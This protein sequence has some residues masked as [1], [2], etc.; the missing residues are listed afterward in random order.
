[1]H[2]SNLKLSTRNFSSIQFTKFSLPIKRIQFTKLKQL[3][4]VVKSTEPGFTQEIKSG[5]CFNGIEE[6]K[7]RDWRYVKS[8]LESEVGV[9]SA[10]QC[11]EGKALSGVTG[12]NLPNCFDNLVLETSLIC[13]KIYSLYSL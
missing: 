6:V 1:M 3:K 13:L 5:G 4:H 10:P 9:L 11:L 8:S 7:M 2:K 12:A